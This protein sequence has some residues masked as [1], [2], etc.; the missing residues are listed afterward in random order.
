MFSDSL[1]QLPLH[2]VPAT[3]QPSGAS[4]AA[5]QKPMGGRKTHRMGAVVHI[6][7]AVD[8]SDVCADGLVTAAQARADVRDGVPQRPA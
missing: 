2:P 3:Q 4:Q 7:L 1:A 5:L 8:V 6:E